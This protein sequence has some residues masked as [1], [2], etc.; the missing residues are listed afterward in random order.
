VAGRLAE[1]LGLDAATI[2]AMRQVYARWDGKGVPALK[3]EAIAPGMLVVS[4]AQDAVYVYRLEGVDAAVALIQKRKGT[5]YALRHVEVFV[6]HARTLFAGLDAEPSW[7]AVLA[8]DPGRLHSGCTGSDTHAERRASNTA[9]PLR[10][11]MHLF[12]LHRRGS[13][14]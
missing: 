9:G 11:G 13:S 3:G 14:D 8:L 12:H 6:R 10:L 5:L 4:L 7:A 1:R 2:S